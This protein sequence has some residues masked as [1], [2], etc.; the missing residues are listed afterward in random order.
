MAASRR[1]SPTRQIASPVGIGGSRSVPESGSDTVP[2]TERWRQVPGLDDRFVVS[3]HGRVRNLLTGGVLSGFPV[4]GGYLQLRLSV[5]QNKSYPYIHDLVARAFLGP[6]PN[7]FDVDHENRVRT[8]NRLKNLRY[9]PLERNRATKS[10]SRCGVT[11]HRKS[12]CRLVALSRE[13]AGVGGGL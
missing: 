6:K 5:H 10:C 7:G 13:A 2:D 11:G 9:L 8:D 3:D 4:R 1:T 12:T